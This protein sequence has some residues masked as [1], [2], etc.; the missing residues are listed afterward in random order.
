MDLESLI[1]HWSGKLPD[2]SSR[3]RHASGATSVRPTAVLPA[4]IAQA[5][6]G[7]REVLRALQ[8]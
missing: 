7:V 8:D 6:R 1:A 2:G 3:R 4:S 5:Q